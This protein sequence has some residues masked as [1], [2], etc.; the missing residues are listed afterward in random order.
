MG[1]IMMYTLFTG[2]VAGVSCDWTAEERR[3][4]LM[5]STRNRYCGRL[6]RPEHHRQPRG[7]SRSH[8]DLMLSMGYLDKTSVSSAERIQK[9][10]G[11]PVIM[12]DG[13][14]TNS[15]A[16]YRFLGGVLD[17]VER[18]G[19]LAAY[20]RKTLDEV[21]TI[22]AAIPSDRQVRVYYAEGLNGLETDPKGSQHA[23]V[24]EMV[25]G[26][27][28]ADVPVLRVRE[29]ECFLGAVAGLATGGYHC[30]RRS[31]LCRRDG[32]LDAGHVEPGM[33]KRRRGEKRQG[34]RDSIV[35]AQLVRPSAFGESHPGFSMAGKPVVSQPFQARHS[36]KTKE[37]YDLFYHKDLTDAELDEVLTHAVAR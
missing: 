10:L 2:K 34:L 26:L 31:Q 17:E 30:L 16:A 12:V 33:A 3:Y 4:L 11:I 27:N 8:P 36:H 15:D 24:L 18:A 35:A 28:V 25:G 37:F 9:Q 21:Q 22:A 19:K 20:C 32:E 14:L 29:G 13:T 23:E 7:D 5:S 1:D 6:V